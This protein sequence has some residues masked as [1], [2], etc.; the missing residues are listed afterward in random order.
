MGRNG[1]HGPLDFA[2]VNAR[3]ITA[4]EEIA[5]GSIVVEGGVITR[6]CESIP[7]GFHEIDLDG[8]LLM[9]GL[10]DLHSDAIE[11]ELQPRPKT[12][13]PFDLAI[14]QADRLFA[15]VGISTAFH[16]L[17]FIGLTSS[18]SANDS[19]PHRPIDD[20]MADFARSVVKVGSHAIIDNRIHVRYEITNKTG[21]EG[22]K[23]LIEDGTASLVSIMDHTPG[24]GQYPDDG[25]FR[26]WLKSTGMTEDQ[27][28]VAIAEK[29]EASRQAKATVDQLTAAVRA[30]GL[31]LA[32]H[33][34]DKPEVIAAHKELGVTITEFPMNLPTC[35]AASAEGLTI[36][37]GSPNIVRGQSTGA[38]PRAMD[39]VE[40]AGANA[41]C[42]DYM[43]ATIL[44]AIFKISEELGMPLWKAVRMGSLTPARAA[45]LFDRGE[46]AV[47]KQ[48]DLIEVEEH[49]GWP[50]VRRL[51]SHGWQTYSSCPLEKRA[52][53]TARL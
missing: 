35:Q 4:D 29:K 12:F 11:H 8:N 6:V 13:L 40:K 19:K 48:A 38:G 24:Q 15:T 47:G 45:H 53:V 14:R 16:S 46:I 50:I 31:P 21:L 9:P 37:V 18:Q 1:G 22:A 28:D 7:D 10:I 17:S 27:I 42:S 36:L 26:D 44:P 23:A 20:V 5:G 51:W 43:P 30:K 34:D 49:F 3:V 41:L 52:V 2:L 32:S 25:A 39:L 33:D